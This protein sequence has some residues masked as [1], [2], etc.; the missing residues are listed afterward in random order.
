MFRLIVCLQRQILNCLVYQTFA[1]KLVVV[2]SVSSGCFKIFVELKLE[3]G[4]GVAKL[5]S[6]S[7]IKRKGRYTIFCFFF[8][9]I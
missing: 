2:V 8:M 9:F 3:C 7:S 6:E 5:S 1:C 4:K